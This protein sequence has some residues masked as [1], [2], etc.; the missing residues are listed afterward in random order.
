MY[1]CC[2]VYLFSALPEDG[3]D[4]PKSQI[5]NRQ[6]LSQN[7]VAVTQTQFR[8]QFS[9][10]CL[11]LRH[12][13]AYGVRESIVLCVCGTFAGESFELP[14]NLFIQL[15][16]SDCMHVSLSCLA[17]LIPNRMGVGGP[18]NLLLLVYRW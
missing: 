17:S 16:M 9:E 6:S 2:N 1:Q 18:R 8:Y 10:L 14:I 3:D 11:R 15:F 5:I 4:G 13:Y 7:A 12:R